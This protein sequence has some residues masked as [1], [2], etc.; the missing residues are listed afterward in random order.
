MA[1]IL[2]VDG[3]YLFKAAKQY[4]HYDYRKLKLL[5]EGLV[6]ERFSESY[7][8]NAIDPINPD[9][10][11][12]FHK[13]MR[14]PEPSGGGFTVKLYQVKGLD[15]V[16]PKCD[17]HFQRNV[18]QG[19]DIGIATL[20]L[21]LGAEERYDKVILCAGDGD[22]EDAIAYAVGK[23]RKTFVR[24]GFSHSLASRLQPYASST[25]FLESHWSAIERDPIPAR[26]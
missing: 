6:G 16:C 17:E 9:A 26:V 14:S 3:D 25:V 23:L 8:L 24:V 10:Q 5:L 13:W 7:Y 19:V 15:C 11:A 4:G 12:G 21:S 18:Q 2:I 1:S 22:F 20:I